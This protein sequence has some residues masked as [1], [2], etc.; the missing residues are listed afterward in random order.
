MA[1]LFSKDWAPIHQFEDDYSPREGLL[2]G[3]DA[4][5]ERKNETKSWKGWIVFTLI[6]IVISLAAVSTVSLLSSRQN[7]TTS[8]EDG[9]LMQK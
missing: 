6:N 7:C 3:N 8:L 4:G 9:K 1:S 2:N 5:L